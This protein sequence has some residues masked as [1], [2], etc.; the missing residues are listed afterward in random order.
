VK[1]LDTSAV[2]SSRIKKEAQI[3]ASLDNEHIIRLHGCYHH[4]RNDRFFCIVMDKL[5]GGDL[6]D[7]LE[8]RGS[9]VSCQDAARLIHQVANGIHYLHQ[10]GFVHR[11]I[12]GENVLMD[13]PSMVDPGV[14]CVIT[15]FGAATRWTPGERLKDQTGTRV[16]WSPEFYD[17]NYAEKVD[18][19]ALG[20]VAYILVTFRM[21]F[22]DEQ[23]ARY[24][25]AVLPDTVDPE[26]R[27]LISWALRKQEEPR[28][29]IE[30]VVK[31]AWLVGAGAREATN[32]DLMTSCEA[33]VA[34]ED[35]IPDKLCATTGAYL[36]PIDDAAAAETSTDCSTI[37]QHSEETSSEAACECEGQCPHLTACKADQ[38]LGSALAWTLE[39][40]GKLHGADT[41]SIFQAVN[42]VVPGSV[43]LPSPRGEQRFQDCL[44]AFDNGRSQIS[45]VAKAAA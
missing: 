8:R 7:G 29:R 19:W 28:A 16:F 41:G 37:G 20:V 45:K 39:R 12:K 35:V 23:S 2:S 4:G 3:L 17:R 26:C 5:E 14:K 33:D 11:D 43:V 32:A 25:E 10:R 1:V 22:A 36:G 40:V 27:D 31:H 30:E 21:P 9:A 18:V 42:L 24:M 44:L 38:A 13:T 34:E 15:D 6:I